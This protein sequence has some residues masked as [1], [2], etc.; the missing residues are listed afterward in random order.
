MSFQFTP[1]DINSSLWHRLKQYLESRRSELRAENDSMTLDER[2]TANKRG[3]IAEISEL[4]DAAN[5][6]EETP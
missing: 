6:R 3:R 4:L 2:Q 5:P 1:S